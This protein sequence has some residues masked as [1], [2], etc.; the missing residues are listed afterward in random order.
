ME[1]GRPGN[2]GFAPSAISNAIARKRHPHRQVLS[3]SLQ[4]GQRKRF[5]AR[6]D[7]PDKNWKFDEGDL[8]ERGF[9]N[10]YMHA[11]RECLEATSTDH[12]PWYAVPADDKPNARLIVSQIILDL[13]EGLKMRYPEVS[14]EKKKRLQAIRRHL[15]K[16][17]H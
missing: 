10:D 7:E 9:W 13:L 17:E 15:S 6:I 4:R 2:T 16:R 1:A 12:A 14:D 3:A 8:A 11:Y 5:L